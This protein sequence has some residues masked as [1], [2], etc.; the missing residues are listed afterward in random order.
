MTTERCL[1]STARRSQWCHV[2]IL[3]ALLLVQSQAWTTVQEHSKRYAPAT[4][5]IS[6]Q[7]TH[8]YSS[9]GSHQNQQHFTIRDCKYGDL[10][11]VSD[12]II[13]SFYEQKM[14]ASPFAA[15][16]KLGELNRLQ[17]NFPYADQQR[18]CM[19]V[20]INDDKQI[21]G[22]VDIDARPATR[23][24]DP[25]RP[26]LSDLA[27][28][29]DYRRKGIAATLIKKCEELV[30]QDKLVVKEKALYIRVEQAN[31]AAIQMYDKFQ[32]QAQKHEIFGVE[33]TTVLLRKHF[34]TATEE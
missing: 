15:V 30:Q 21:V 34:T 12:I 4:S 22:F 27:V 29:P 17:Q 24:I 19:F 23:R 18:H 16:L 28:H 33:D 11:A 13:S 26:Y 10:K 31:G 5:A 2:V 14:R 7:R 25:P 9:S 3:V 8:L 20:A 1:G 6:L 32:Y